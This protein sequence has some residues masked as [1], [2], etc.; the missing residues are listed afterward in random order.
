MTPETEAVSFKISVNRVLAHLS[1][2]DLDHL[3][4][5]KSDHPKPL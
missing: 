4:A 1:F 2:Q 3:L 5:F